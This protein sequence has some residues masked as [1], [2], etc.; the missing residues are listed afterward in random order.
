[1]ERNR[2]RKKIHV[3]LFFNL[4][5]RWGNCRGRVFGIMLKF[6]ED[7]NRGELFRGR[8][9]KNL[10]DSWLLED[11]LHASLLLTSYRLFNK[12]ALDAM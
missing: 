9:T 4:V 12:T 6:A 3:Y 5:F 8:L 7:N 11:E 1:M 10:F 2:E